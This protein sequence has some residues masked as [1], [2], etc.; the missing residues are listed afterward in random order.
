MGKAA[1]ESD[2]KRLGFMICKIEAIVR[3]NLSAGSLAATRSVNLVD[4]IES[5]AVTA[6]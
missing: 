5:L 4:D 2:R 6:N 1:I 3:T